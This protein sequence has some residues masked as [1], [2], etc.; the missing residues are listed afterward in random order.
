MMHSKIS[1]VILE[2]VVEKHTMS[3]T[4]I[5][6]Q[7][8]EEEVIKN[9]EETVELSESLGKVSGNIHDVQTTKF[10]EKNSSIRTMRS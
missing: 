8:L 1:N 4:D 3:F 10:H 9:V 7:Q 6:K 2:N 5:V